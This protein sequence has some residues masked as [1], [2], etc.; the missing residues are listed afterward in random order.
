[1]TH[2]LVTLTAFLLGHAGGLLAQGHANTSGPLGEVPGFENEYV[3]VHYVLYEPA[4][5]KGRFPE[6]APIVIYIAVRHGDGSGLRLQVPPPP[7]RARQ[8]WRPGVMARG[9][10]VEVLQPPLPPSDLGEPGTEQPGDSLEREHWPGG[11]LVWATFRPMDYGV[12][13]G[14]FPSVTTFLSD[15]VIEVWH[16]RET[17]RR[18][19]VQA[20][21][22]FWF[23][24]GTR[25]TVVDDYPIGAAIVQLEPGVEAGGSIHRTPVESA[26]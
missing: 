23:E 21:D 10:H 5:R 9:I 8:S 13:A 26:R 12:G 20:G 7:A 1:M 2:R 14:R 18:I 15:G 4:L 17:R 16:R 6:D 22:T 3:R 19:G 11:Q 25:I 24:A